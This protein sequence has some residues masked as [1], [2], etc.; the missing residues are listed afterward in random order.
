MVE[1]RKLDVPAGIVEKLNNQIKII[2]STLPDDLKGILL[3]KEANSDNLE[4]DVS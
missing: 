3:K 2:V 1:E 4:Q